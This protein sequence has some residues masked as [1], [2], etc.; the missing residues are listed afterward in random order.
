VHKRVPPHPPLDAPCC[1]AGPRGQGLA[2]QLSCSSCSSC[3]VDQLP[4]LGPEAQD[5]SLQVQAVSSALLQ[6]V[7]PLLVGA[8]VGDHLREGDAERLG[9]RLWGGG[10]RRGERREA[11]EREEGGE[12]GDERVGRGEEVRG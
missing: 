5:G 9:S 10:E 12:G 7:L 6:R 4:L 2:G 11:E 1:V 8:V 3:S